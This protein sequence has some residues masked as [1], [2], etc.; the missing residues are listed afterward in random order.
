MSTL[1]PSND[2]RRFRAATLS[3]TAAVLLA[4]SG[5]PVM[6]QSGHKTIPPRDFRATSA[7]QVSEHCAPANGAQIMGGFAG[8]DDRIDSVTGEICTR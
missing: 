1:S 8:A 4:A 2:P 3:F 5:V 6:S 7:H